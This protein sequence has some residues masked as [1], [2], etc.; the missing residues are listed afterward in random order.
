[1]KIRDGV[2]AKWQDLAAQLKFESGVIEII[3]TKSK[4]CCEDAF[5]DLMR[6]WLRG[7]GKQPAS[8]KTLLQALDAADF[9]TLASDVKKVLNL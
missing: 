9:K 3:E 8:W 6:R 4:G 2:A 5:D 7:A 1:M